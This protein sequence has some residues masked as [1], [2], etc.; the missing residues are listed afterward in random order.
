[1][2]FMLS[3]FQHRD[4]GHPAFFRRVPPGREH[5]FGLLTPGCASLTRGYYHLVPPE[6][7]TKRF[8]QSKHEGR[9]RFLK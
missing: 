5:R 9:W 2:G 6:V 8:C 7:V 1:M 4:L 3:R